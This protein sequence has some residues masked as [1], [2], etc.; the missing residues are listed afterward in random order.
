M[1]L[2][3]LARSSTT[4]NQNDIN[5]SIILI[6]KICGILPDLAQQIHNKPYSKKN[7]VNKCYMVHKNLTWSSTKKVANGYAGSSQI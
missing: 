2:R 4:D 7:N 6:N 1:D 5:N 3:D